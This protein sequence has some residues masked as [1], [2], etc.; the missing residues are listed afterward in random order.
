M[1]SMLLGGDP[2]S[3]KIAK[4]LHQRFQ[5][6][7]PRD[8]A[9]QMSLSQATLGHVARSLLFDNAD[10][11]VTEAAILT[12]LSPRYILASDSAIVSS[13]ASQ[14]STSSGSDEVVL[15]TLVLDSAGIILE[16]MLFAEYWDICWD[17][18]PFLNTDSIKKAA[19]CAVINR[20]LGPR[21]INVADIAL[22]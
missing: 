20:Y 17:K 5:R 3:L 2:W 16:G 21:K 14:G 6:Q 11:V 1:H 19:I 4:R 8:L 13:V 12:P 18:L 15:T 7:D 10:H 22:R 9:R